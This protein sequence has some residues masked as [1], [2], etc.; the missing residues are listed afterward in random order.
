M[1]RP[2]FQHQGRR[3]R[4]ANDTHRQIGHPANAKMGQQRTSES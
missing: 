2:H 1:R 3:L 4:K